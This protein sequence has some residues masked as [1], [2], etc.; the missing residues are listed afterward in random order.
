VLACA[1]TLVW[2]HCQSIHQCYRLDRLRREAARLEATCEA[3]DARVS[4]LRQPHLLA[5]RL[6]T[7]KLSLVSPFDERPEQQPV[8]LAQVGNGGGR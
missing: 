2:L 4:R 1:V 5:A 3:L 8:R 6:E 7:M